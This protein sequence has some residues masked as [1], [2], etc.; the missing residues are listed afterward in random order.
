MSSTE[1]NSLTLPS[2][3]Q[4]TSSVKLL[5]PRRAL[6]SRHQQQRVHD[7]DDGGIARSGSPLARQSFDSGEQGVGQQMGVG[8]QIVSLVVAQARRKSEESIL[9]RV[10]FAGGD[11]ADGIVAWRTTAQVR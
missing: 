5:P 8:G 9:D 1:N 3:F 10:K 2:L 6:G 4:T 11:D 7:E